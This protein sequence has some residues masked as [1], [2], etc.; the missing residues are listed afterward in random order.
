MQFKGFSPKT[1]EYLH[2]VK[3]NNSKAWYEEHRED[4]KKYVRQPFSDLVEDLTPVIR[5]IDPDLVTEPSKCLSRIY[6][7]T[8]FTKD[9]HL[10]RDSAWIAF[11]RPFD[12]SCDG[13]TFFAEIM[14]EGARYGMG[15]FESSPKTMAA[16][17]KYITDDPD[18]FAECTRPITENGLCVI[19]EKYKYFPSGFTARAEELG[20]N[21]WYEMKK[22]FIS[23]PILAHEAFFTPD[24][25]TEIS[26]K[27]KILEPF[28]KTLCQIERNK[29]VDTRC[30]L[31]KNKIEDFEW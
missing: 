30:E 27:F 28:Y 8:R 19:S 13:I 7:D 2:N 21:S 9:K 23:S 15:A 3:A 16:M 26:E 17:R 20:L 6:R 5:R 14:S 4:Y 1:T 29:F 24:I 18:K 31:P 10:Y 12:N 22:F 25:V 11:R